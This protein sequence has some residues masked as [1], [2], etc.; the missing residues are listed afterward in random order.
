M[1]NS[2]AHATFS[3]ALRGCRLCDLAQIAGAS[4]EPLGGARVG[5]PRQQDGDRRPPAE[6]ALDVQPAAA[7]PGEAE[8]LAQAEPAAAAA[9]LGR[10][11]GL[12]GAPND[13]VGHAL[14]MVADLE[15]D[16]VAGP[17][18]GPQQRVEFGGG[19]VAHPDLD[20]PTLGRR[21]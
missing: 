18:I 2:G 9:A 13:V 11:E 19:E 1:T 5:R 21:V 12:A 6:R 14:A 20:G 4:V 10:E 17:Q 16:V 3:E 8:H 15:D 7:L